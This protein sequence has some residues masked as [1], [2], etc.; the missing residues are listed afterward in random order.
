[1]FPA[2][3][4]WCGI[5]ASSHGRITTL[6]EFVDIYTASQ[7]EYHD[8]Q[9]ELSREDTIRTQSFNSHYP[10]LGLEPKRGHSC[11]DQVSLGYCFADT[12]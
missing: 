1:M 8:L 6:A 5:F 4:I 9:Q 2:T 7:L 12:T 3:A 11:V 10:I